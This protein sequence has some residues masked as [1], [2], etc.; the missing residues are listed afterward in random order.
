VT[1]VVAHVDEVVEQIDARCA[2]AEQHEGQRDGRERL[3]ARRLVAG[4]QRHEH[5]Q[6]LGP[7]VYAQCGDPRDQPGS[8][9]GCVAHIVE[10]RGSELGGQVVAF[11]DAVTAGGARPP[12][13]RSPGSEPRPAR[14]GAP[15]HAPR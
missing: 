8:A 10:S 15:L 1:A 9:G 13:G 4:Q 7:L 3:P 6:V 14:C 11:R 5:Q 12:G 2:Q